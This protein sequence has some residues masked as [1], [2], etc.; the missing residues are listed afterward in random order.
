MDQV[1]EPRIV[2]SRVGDDRDFAQVADRRIRPQLVGLTSQITG[3]RVRKLR[4][5]VHSVAGS[6]MV[7]SVS[8]IRSQLVH[9]AGVSAPGPR[10]IERPRTAGPASALQ[11]SPPLLRCPPSSTATLLTTRLSA[12]GGGLTD[13]SPSILTS[14]TTGVSRLRRK[15]RVHEITN[16]GIVSLI[17]RTRGC[18][19]G[20]PKCGGSR[21]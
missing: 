8:C 3:V 9:G 4:R 13:W 12:R 6:T 14:C 7:R 16:P 17:H 21:M 19:S 5:T 18:S 10:R 11:V 2:A 20:R 15:G 1:A